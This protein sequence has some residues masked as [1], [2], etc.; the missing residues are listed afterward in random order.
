MNEWERANSAVIKPSYNNL[1]L[2]ILKKQKHLLFSKVKGTKT[3]TWE[4]GVE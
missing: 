1:S 2:Y 3:L 4:L